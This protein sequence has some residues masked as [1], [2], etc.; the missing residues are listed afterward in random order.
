[1]QIKAIFYGRGGQGAKSSA[2]IFAK[3]AI[4][5]GNY[6]Q[7]FSKFGAEKS[8][9]PV[10]SF[11]KISDQEIFSHEPFEK[12]DILVILDD[13]LLV[14]NPS[15]LDTLDKESQIKLIL[16]NSKNQTIIDNLRKKMKNINI[17]DIDATGIALK[18]IKKNAPNTTLLAKLM[19]E[20]NKNNYNF[21]I[22]Y[23][24]KVVSDLFEDDKDMIERNKKA[25]KEVTK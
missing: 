14:F 2:D 20:L 23:L 10:F 25:I 6:A 24:I 17:I 9:T 13:T 3:A 8:G 21:K 4:Y 16:V 12:C 22:D 18:N 19:T 1:M 15:I 11:L 7:S 5:Q